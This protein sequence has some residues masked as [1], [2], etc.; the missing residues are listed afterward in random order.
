[1]CEISPTFVLYSY[2]SVQREGREC[3]ILLGGFI[4]TLYGHVLVG[5]HNY[6]FVHDCQYAAMDTTTH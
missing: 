3:I 2:F 4:H 1:M 5:S 6:Y